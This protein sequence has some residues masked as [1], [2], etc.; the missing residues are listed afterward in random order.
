MSTYRHPT[1]NW[2][3]VDSSHVGVL[4]NEEADRM[5]NEATT[6]LTNIFIDKMPTR[7]VR[8]TKKNQIMAKLLEL[9]LIIVTLSL[10]NQLKI[11]KKIID[12]WP[13]LEN[14]SRRKQIVINRTRIGHTHSTHSFFIS[15][16]PRPMCDIRTPLTVKHVTIYYSKLTTAHHLLNSPI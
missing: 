5:A 13:Y 16:E 3:Y 15:K 4:G 10:K 8:V 1:K 6:S 7:D 2:V 12:K 9:Y 11:L 14:T